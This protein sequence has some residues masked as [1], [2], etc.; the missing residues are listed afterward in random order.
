MGY[1]PIGNGWRKFKREGGIG[2]S[3]TSKTVILSPVT[4]VEE[5]VLS[6]DGFI[7]TEG[8]TYRA[9]W[10]GIEYVSVCRTYVRKADGKTVCYIGDVSD[11]IDGQESTGEPFYAAQYAK[12]GGLFSFATDRNYDGNEHTLSVT[13]ETET[14]HTIDPKYLPNPADLPSDWIA[15]LKA[16]LGI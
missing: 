14:V 12:D 10:D 4:V 1:D 5:A 16:A 3:E 6:D 15:D 7:L 13:H 9:V 11:D 8:E 2:Y